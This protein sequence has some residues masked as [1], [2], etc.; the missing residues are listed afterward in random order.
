M[1]INAFIDIQCSS[2]LKL[3]RRIHAANMALYVFM[4]T[5]WTFNNDNFKALEN[6]IPP[7]DL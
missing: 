1:S 7:E 2:L 5:E 4:T 6:I 3:Q